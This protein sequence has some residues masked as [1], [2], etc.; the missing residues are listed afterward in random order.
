MTDPPEDEGTPPSI[1]PPEDEGLHMVRRDEPE[2]NL[3]YT[4]I[5]RVE[6]QAPEP[7]KPERFTFF[8]LGRVS[9]IVGIV[10]FIGFL[11][12]SPYLI[13]QLHRE[14]GVPEAATP[15]VAASIAPTAAPSAPKALVPITP[16]MF[17]V[18][19]I[20]LGDIRLTVVNGKQLAEGDWL[21]V[22]TPDGIIQVRL[23]SI[24]DGIV[25]FECDDRRIDA[26]LT[27]P[28]SVRK[29]P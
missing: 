10:F 11:V 16:D 23:T 17:H 18:T 27:A 26:K 6:R 4:A 14:A 19:S 8:T 5:S 1:T 21:P 28:S 24:E 3:L 29:S 15:S 25:H 12:A 9:V 20:S 22:Q 2:P 13:Q 7:D